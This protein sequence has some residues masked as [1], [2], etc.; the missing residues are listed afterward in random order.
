MFATKTNDAHSPCKHGR[1]HLVPSQPSRIQVILRTLC[2][3]TPGSLLMHG[4]VGMVNQIGMEARSCSGGKKRAL[5]NTTH[6]IIFYH[7]EPFEG[8]AGRVD[9]SSYHPSLLARIIFVSL[10]TRSTPAKRSFSKCC[11]RRT[12][13]VSY[14]Y[15]VRTCRDKAIIKVAIRVEGSASNLSRRKKRRRALHE[16]YLLPHNCCWLA[17]PF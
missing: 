15:Y 8:G 17:T 9:G 6:P 16:S 11:C 1:W 13:Y 10:F 14:V 5:T 3:G 7:T 12:F 4:P 2:S